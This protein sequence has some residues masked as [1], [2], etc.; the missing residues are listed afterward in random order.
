MVI[1]LTTGAALHSNL[2]SLISSQLLTFIVFS[3]R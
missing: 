3:A 2:I 1:V